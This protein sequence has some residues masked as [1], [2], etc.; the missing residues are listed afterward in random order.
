[1][2]TPKLLAAG[3]SSVNMTPMIDVVFL[4]IIFFLVSSHLAKQEN[5]IELALPSAT[6]ALDD[7]AQR[8]SL[9]VNVLADGQWQIGGVLVDSAAAAKRLRGRVMQTGQPVQ[10]RIRSDRDVPYSR[11]EPLLRVATDAGIGDIVFSVL[12]E[13][14]R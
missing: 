7:A 3:T 2:R 14:V 4:L 6:S 5:Q 1:M 13:R 8:E 9:T 10:L 11:I 12:E